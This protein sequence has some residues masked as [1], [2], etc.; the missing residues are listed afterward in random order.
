MKFEILNRWSGKIIFEC[1]ALSLK[2]AVEKAVSSGVSLSAAD[3]SSADL[4]AATGKPGLAGVPKIENIHQ[5]VYQAASQP[6]ALDMGGWHTCETTH[7]RAG[8]VVH[9]AGAAGK[10][11][12]FCIGTAAAAALIYLKSDPKLE[13]VPD[14][15]ALNSDALEDMRLLAEKEAAHAL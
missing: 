13:K 14:F 12:E 10:A 7:C 6:D 9:L 5:V 3:L 11:M 8:W 4:S 15:Y 1:D 2:L